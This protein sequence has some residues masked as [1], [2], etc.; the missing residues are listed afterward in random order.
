ML[1]LQD[2]EYV[3]YTVELDDAAGSIAT[4]LPPPP[5]WSF[6]GPSSLKITPAA[7]GMSVDVAAVGPLGSAQL[8]FSATNQDGK[9][10][11][12]NDTITVVPSEAVSVKLVA[13]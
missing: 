7:D 13:G 5:E 2:N 6:S 3:D 1:N 9:A 4:A 8:Q 10:V 11:T 12:G